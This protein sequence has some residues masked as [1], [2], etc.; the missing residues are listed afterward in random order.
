MHPAGCLGAW[1]ALTTKRS[2][3]TWMLGGRLLLNQD[4]IEKVR[5]IYW[6]HGNG[7]GVGRQVYALLLRRGNVYKKGPTRLLA[8]SLK[9]S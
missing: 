7:R 3:G 6:F 9:P 5:I 8:L 2:W 4:D 1:R